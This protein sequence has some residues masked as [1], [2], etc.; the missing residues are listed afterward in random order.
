MFAPKVLALV[1]ALGVAS[2]AHAADNAL[3]GAH[4][5]SLKASNGLSPCEIASLMVGKGTMPKDSPFPDL[6]PQNLTQYPIPTVEEADEL[7]CNMIFYNLV[8]GCSACQLTTNTWASWDDWT[9]HCRSQTN[10]AYIASIMPYNTPLPSWTFTD[11]IATGGTFNSTAAEAVAQ[12]LF[13]V[14][15]T[16]FNV[17][18]S[19]TTSG[20]TASTSASTSST[21]SSV[22]TGAIAGGTVGGFAAGGILGALV[23]FLAARKKAAKSTDDGRHSINSQD[24]RDTIMEE[25]A[26][27]DGMA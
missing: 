16:I 3:C 22:N 14:P 9:S 21:S 17:K 8:S 26:R 18:N 2:V 15:D 10:V 4:G 20:S 12:N 24:T 5:I 27:V 23:T 6:Q 7:H 13:D 1:A 25:K 19:T 11:A